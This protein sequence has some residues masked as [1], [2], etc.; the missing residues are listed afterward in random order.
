MKKLLLSFALL[1]LAFSSSA[2]CTPGANYPDA[3]F[4]DSTYG[5]W[6]DT[7]V[8]FPGGMV[9]EYYT[10]DLSFK[11]PVNAGDIDPAYDGATIASFS[12]DSVVGYPV[13]FDYACN[14]SNCEYSGGAFGCARLFGTTVTPGLYEIEIFLTA[15]VII[16]PGFPAV[17]VSQSFRGY[18]IEVGELG[19][20]QLI[21]SSVTMHP[22]PVLDELTLEGLST[23]NFESIAIYN[24]KGQLV[25]ALE[26]NKDI[27][28]VNVSSI[29]QG[30][31][32]VHLLGENGTTVK[33]FVKK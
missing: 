20:T 18:K 30:I 21:E 1:T 15:D 29:E 32:F 26:S 16:V 22:N 6:P 2:Q 7:V 23:Y 13:E 11:V 3:N 17:P 4:A 19:L 14:I 9:N 5:A 27:I 31:Y 24:M 8:N 33:T 25:H 28:E 10:T 12:V